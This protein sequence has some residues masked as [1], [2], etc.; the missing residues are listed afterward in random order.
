MLGCIRAGVGDVAFV[1][2]SQATQT[3]SR[4]PSL[5]TEI[6][7]HQIMIRLGAEN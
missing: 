3:T 4:E 2:E 6:L 1:G 7:A 5:R